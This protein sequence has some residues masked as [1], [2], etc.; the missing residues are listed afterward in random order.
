MKQI[1]H[2][3]LEGESST[4][5]LSLPGHDNAKFILIKIAANKKQET[6]IQKGIT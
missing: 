2:M 3:F 1:T 5:P 6:K 4:L